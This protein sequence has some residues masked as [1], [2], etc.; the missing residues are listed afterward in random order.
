[1]KIKYYIIAGATLLIFSVFLLQRSEKDVV[2]QLQVVVS[3]LTEK[4]QVPVYVNPQFQQ[5]LD[6]YE[7]E[8]RHMMRVSGIPGAAIAIVKDSNIVFLKGFGVKI[9]NGKDSVN[10]NTVFRIASVS[11]CF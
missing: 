11:K 7:Q 5:L 10:E 1:M 6:E 2:S 9:A 3:P 4:K 8:I